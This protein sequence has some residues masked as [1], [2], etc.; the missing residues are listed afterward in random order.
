MTVYAVC[1]ARLPQLLAVTLFTFFFISGIAAYDDFGISWDECYSR[2]LTG[3]VSTQF[4]K[5]LNATPY[6][7]NTEKYHGPLFENLLILAEDISGFTDVRQIYLLRH[8]M[9]FLLFFGAC[10]VFYMLVHTCLQ[11]HWMALAACGMLILSPRIF[12]DSFYNT[13][14]LPMLS[15]YIFCMCTMLRVIHYS[16][17]KWIVVHAIV[18][19]ALMAIR[20]NGVIVPLLTIAVLVYKVFAYK[21]HF[22][23]LLKL[24]FIYILAVAIA[25]TLFWPILWLNPPE[26]FV[27][28]FLEMV[29]YH[30]SETVVFRN[31]I[32][33]AQNLPWY[34]LPW[35]MAISIPP[36]YM[37]LALI[38]FA[39]TLSLLIY[40]KFCLNHHELGTV[41]LHAMLLLPLT[42][43][44]ILQSVIYD[45]WRHMYFVYP[46]LILMATFGL[47]K[48]LN[49]LKSRIIA[50]ATLL[51]SLLATYTA[52]VIFL[53]IN[54]PHQM[55]YFN[56]LASIKQYEAPFQYEM[57]YWG[58]S[59]R[60]ALEFIV[61]SDKRDHIKIAVANQ[62]GI[63]NWNMLPIQDRSRLQVSDT[64]SEYDYYLTNYRFANRK[65]EGLIEIYTIK[66]DGITIAG[67]YKSGVK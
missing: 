28:A 50:K 20:I 57:D 48:L 5:T 9:T 31:A 52:M 35:W 8:L 59:Y 38:G 32:Y 63:N 51:T 33:P 26:H 62:P 66:S 21:M 54:H 3:K 4:I 7:E 58:L 2:D 14:D 16:S 15:F 43:V 23:R 29:R 60:N 55:V 36:L 17:I 41:T 45:G 42:A 46:S 67:V 27:R 47:S 34:Y 19:G 56:V 1:K 65:P 49:D 24:S 39:Y 22:Y 30:W 11:S 37:L 13:K 53:F 10:F 64:L 18:C 25:V 12:A 44:I 61:R 6:L 40:K